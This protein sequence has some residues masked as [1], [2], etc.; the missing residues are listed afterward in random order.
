MIILLTDQQCR[1]QSL[2]QTCLALH[3]HD[4]DRGRAIAD[5]QLVQILRIGNDN[6]YGW[7]S[8]CGGLRRSEGARTVTGFLHPRRALCHRWR[9]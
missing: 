1:V 2:F 6:I 9:L 8:A 3:G 5:D 4:E 7:I